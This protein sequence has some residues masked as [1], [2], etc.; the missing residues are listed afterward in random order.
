MGSRA[1]KPDANPKARE[2][3]GQLAVDAHYHELEKIADPQQRAAA[4]KAL[5]E[6]AEKSVPATGK[7][8]EQAK[9][10]QA[11]WEQRL[12]SLGENNPARIAGEKV[13]T[14]IQRRQNTRI[15]ANVIKAARKDADII[16]RAQKAS[17]SFRQR[18][19]NQPA[20]D[21]DRER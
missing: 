10:A 7:A 15:A 13:R 11:K 17:T 8:V 21:I 2:E 18:A 19:Q 16:T 5:R 20:R 14:A 12:N 9:A 6:H 3:A 1:E 4:E